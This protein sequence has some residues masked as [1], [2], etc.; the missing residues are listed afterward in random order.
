ML[1]VS[2]LSSEIKFNIYV[3]GF[4]HYVKCGTAAFEQGRGDS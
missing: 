4:D 1:L 2:L 3:G